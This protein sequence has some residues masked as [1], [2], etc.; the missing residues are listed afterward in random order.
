MTQA[1]L[2]RAVARATGESLGTIRR[3]GF[4][5]ADPA[6]TDF[7]PEPYNPPSM[8]DWDDLDANRLAILP[9]RSAHRRLAA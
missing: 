2:N 6:C 7:D 3:R 1:K 8:V 9:N 4:S 5:I